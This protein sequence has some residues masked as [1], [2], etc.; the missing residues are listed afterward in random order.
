MH[1]EK[2]HIN[3]AEFYR[4]A[5]E[6]TT[7]TIDALPHHLDL[8]YG[9]LP[10]QR[11]DLYLPPNQPE[12]APVLL[13][14]HGGGFVEGD[15]SNYGFVAR[16]FAMHGIITAIAN[17]R[18]TS[19]GIHY[20][21]QSNDAKV[22]IMWLYENIKSYGGNP[23]S[24]YVSGHSAGAILAADV[25]VNRAW[26]P[27]AGIPAGALKGA[28]AISALYDIQHEK[29]LDDYTPTALLRYAASPLMHVSNPTPEFLVIVGGKRI[30]TFNL[31]KI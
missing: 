7:E 23:D 18:L 20:P 13:F 4:Q 29:R 25:S 30:T 10:K 8:A 14:L 6:K 11:L 15:K 26:L 24:I 5:N 27:R 19:G 3:W 2:Y 21:A 17:Y 12:N 9:D 28:F 16:P 31:P 22:A 1:P